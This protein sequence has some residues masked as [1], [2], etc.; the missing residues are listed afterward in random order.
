MEK[1]IILSPKDV[2]EYIRDNVETLDLLELSYNRIF[3]PGEVL[4]IDH[5]DDETKEGLRVTMQLNG[6]M[7]NQT[8][9]VDIHE[10][11]DDLLEVRHVKKETTLTTILVVEH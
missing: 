7:L 11:I 1:E 6:E 8:V 2:I 10:I 5:E 3:A 4:Y 9:E